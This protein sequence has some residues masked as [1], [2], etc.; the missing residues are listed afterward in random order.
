MVESMRP[1]SIILDISIDQG[2][3]VATSRPTTHTNPT[4]I[5]ADV[6]HYCVPNMTGVLGRTATHALN[7]A[8]W[9]FIQRIAELGLD[10]AI[11]RSPALDRGVYTRQGE[12]IHPALK[13]AMLNRS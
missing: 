5:E 11:K 12:L 9:P 3:C 1:R 6:I 10:E 8:T 4:F 7:N 2:G 13:N